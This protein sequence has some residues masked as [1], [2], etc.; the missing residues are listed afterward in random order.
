MKKSTVLACASFFLLPFTAFSQ[1][2]KQCLDLGYIKKERLHYRITGIMYGIG[3]LKL[4][5]FNLRNNKKIS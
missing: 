4:K 5:D 2:L 1:S 3:I